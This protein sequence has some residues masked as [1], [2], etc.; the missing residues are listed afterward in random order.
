MVILP[1][2]AMMH[3]STSTSI[4]ARS[5][6]LY[7][8]PSQKTIQSALV[9]IT[10]K[11]KYSTGTLGT[12]AGFAVLAHRY[13]PVQ[14]PGAHATAGIAIMFQLTSASI[15]RVCATQVLQPPTAPRS[16]PDSAPNPAM[17][18][19]SLFK[20]CRQIASSS[21]GAAGRAPS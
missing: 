12:G 9:L 3:R 20:D 21:Q 10:G 4:P 6:S 17:S 13:M 15:T 14:P 8:P 2:S 11:I 16:A 19:S 1:S 7:L 18:G 5:L